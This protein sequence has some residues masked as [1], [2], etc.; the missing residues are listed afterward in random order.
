MQFNNWNEERK[1]KQLE[2]ELISDLYIDIVEDY[3]DIQRNI[4]TTEESFLRPLKYLD[5]CLIAIQPVN[6]SDLKN[7]LQIKMG[8][9]SMSMNIGA[10][11]SFK[12]QGIALMKNSRLKIKLFEYYESGLNQLNR[13]QESQSKFGDVYIMPLSIKY[14]DNNFEIPYRNY[15]DLRK[16][17]ESKRVISYWIRMYEYNQ[18]I[19]KKL[20]PLQKGLKHEMEKE[21]IANGKDPRQILKEAI[22]S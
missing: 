13:Q 20:T 11:E 8:R 12:H 15:L 9:A 3:N 7:K 16:D 14:C 21:L 10:Y 19:N 18:Y 5:S 17:S 1:L 4:V 6:L 2:L 22:K